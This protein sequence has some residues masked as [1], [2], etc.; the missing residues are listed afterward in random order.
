MRHRASQSSTLCALAARALRAGGLGLLSLGLLSLGALTACEEGPRPAEKSP[1]FSPPS[2]TSN[3]PMQPPRLPQCDPDAP[4]DPGPT[5]A[6]RLSRVEY[7]HSVRDL[8]GGERPMTMARDGFMP[9]EVMLGF[10]NNA[11]ALQVTPVHAE[12]YLTAAEALARQVVDHLEDHLICDLSALGERACAAAFIDAFGRRAWRRP[13]IA[14]EQDRLLALFDAAPGLMGDPEAEPEDEPLPAEPGDP[15]ADAYRAGLLRVVEALLQSPHFLYRIEVGA[16]VPGDATLRR[17]DAYEVAS[18]LSYFLW[19]SMPDDVLFDAASRNAL[20][21][22]D[23]IG[24]Q[25]RRMLADARAREG[26]WSFFEQWLQLDGIASL[27]RDPRYYPNFGAAQK[28]LLADEARAF[29]EHHV[30]GGSGDL[31][32]LFDSAEGFRNAKLAEFYEESASGMPAGTLTLATLDPERRRGLLTLGAV[33]ARHSKPTMSSPIHR[34]IFVREQILCTALPSPPPNVP[35][36][37]PDPDPELT[38]REKFAQHT[39]N[40]GCASCHR[41]IDGLGFAFEHYDAV[42][43]WRDDELGNPIDSAGQ[44]VATLD[45][46]GTYAGGSALAEALAGSEQVHRCVATQVFRYAFGRGEAPVDDCTLTAMYDAYTAHDTHDFLALVEAV[47]RTETF[48]FRR[49][50][51]MADT[52]APTVEAGR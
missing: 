11:R 48:R 38:T 6:R 49:A 7:D 15:E 14:E 25:T 29:V 51:G 2:G 5:L 23:D 26:L 46:D 35:T 52:P 32:R 21:T 16:P 41:L 43:R 12:Q 3:P 37:A 42:G 33:L 47:T 30:W 13:L 1:T 36:I 31:A 39:E 40:E 4:I 22:P 9:D 19:R 44:V 24:R 20:D 17:L 50:E 28:Q 10:D 45:L 27:D 18:R 34:G 8:L